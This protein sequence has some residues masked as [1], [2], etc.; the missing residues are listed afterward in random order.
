MFFLFG[1]LF[2]SFVRVRPDGE[3]L[4]TLKGFF[5]LHLSDF[6]FE[7]IQDINVA[8]G[9]LSS[10]SPITIKILISPKYFT[11]WGKKH[12]SIKIANSFL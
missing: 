12:G 5:L 6:S 4:F 11:T 7:L 2:S 8:E 3:E 1:K 10:K 9:H